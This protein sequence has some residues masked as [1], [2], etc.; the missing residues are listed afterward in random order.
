DESRVVRAL[1]FLAQA[2]KQIAEV[3]V[4]D[5]EVHPVELIGQRQDQRGQRA[6]V[7]RLSRQNIQTDTLRLGRLIEQPI[8]VGALQRFGNALLRQR[9]EL[10]HGFPT[11]GFSQQ[12]YHWIV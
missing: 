2:R 10:E 11:E 6:L 3:G 7:V 8:A 1:V 4:A 9:L 5:A 12:S